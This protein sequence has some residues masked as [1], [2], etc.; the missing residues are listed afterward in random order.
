MCRVCVGDGSPK[1]SKPQTCRN[2]KLYI[3][4]N[5][6]FEACI[7]CRNNSF[8]SNKLRFDA[9]C[10]M[11]EPQQLRNPDLRTFAD[12]CV[13]LREICV[14]FA[15]KLSTFLL[16]SEQFW[17]F[18]RAFLAKKHGRSVFSQIQK[19]TV[20]FNVYSGLVSPIQQRLLLAW[21][22]SLL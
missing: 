19:K 11:H 21:H 2:T 7:V 8:H 18:L 14:L 4:E 22:Q 12:I 1:D 9:I 3:F 13:F 15:G 17:N 16:N 10:H 6:L 20:C 5:S